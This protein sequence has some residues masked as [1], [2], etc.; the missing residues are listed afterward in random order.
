MDIVRRKLIWALLGLKGLRMAFISKSW[1]FTIWHLHGQTSR[2]LEWSNGTQNLG[3]VY[4]VSESRLPFVQISC[5][6]TAKWPQRH[7]TDIKNG[8]GVMD[9]ESPCGPYIPTGK[10]VLPFQT[11]RCTRKFSTKTTQ[12]VVFHLLSNRIF[13]NLFVNGKQPLFLKSLA[14]VK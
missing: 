3:L 7:E 2:P 8:F 1:L 13:R 10:T 12:K 9:H 11:S 4:F 5:I 14:T 6:F